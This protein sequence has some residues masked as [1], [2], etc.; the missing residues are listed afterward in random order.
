MT[1]FLDVPDLSRAQ[2]D[3]L[4]EIYAFGEYSRKSKVVR[5][6][7]RT[8]LVEEFPGKP[9]TILLTDKGRLWCAADA[10]VAKE[11]QL[12]LSRGQQSG[13]GKT[14]RSILIVY[15]RNSIPLR[16]QLAEAVG[17]LADL[18]KIQNGQPVRISVQLEP[19]KVD[20]S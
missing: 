11:R 1:N 6:L 18:Q 4:R 19:V 14:K 5:A 8:D 10:K 15:G 7:L 20:G 17:D 3:A 9:G 12:E 2:C 13:T 16:D